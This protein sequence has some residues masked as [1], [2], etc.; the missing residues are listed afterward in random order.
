LSETAEAIRQ[1]IGGNA[2]GKIVITV[3]RDD[4]I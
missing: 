1:L 3:N 2:R 4:S